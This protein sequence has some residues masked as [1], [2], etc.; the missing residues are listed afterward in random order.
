MDKNPDRIDPRKIL[1][2]AREAVREVVAGKIRLFG[3]AGKA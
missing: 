3:C 2:P 1:A